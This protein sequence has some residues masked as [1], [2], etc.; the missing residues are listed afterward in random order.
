MKK[1]EEISNLNKELLKMV[2]FTFPLWNSGARFWLEHRGPSLARKIADAPGLKLWFQAPPIGD[3]DYALKICSLFADHVI[4]GHCGPLP[5]YHFGLAFPWRMDES[6]EIPPPT[7]QTAE[8]IG[9]PI[10]YH[11]RVDAVRRPLP[12]ISKQCLLGPVRTAVELGIVTYFPASIIYAPLPGSVWSSPVEILS[13]EG[14]LPKGHRFIGV[15]KEFAEKLSKESS[16]IKTDWSKCEQGYPEMD[17]PGIPKMWEWSDQAIKWEYIFS[18]FIASGGVEPAKES[19]VQISQMPEAIFKL[20]LPYLKEADWEDIYKIRE[21]EKGALES[22]RESILRACSN[23]SAVHG[24]KKFENAV[25]DIQERVVDKGIEEVRKAFKSL[26]FRKWA[27]IAGLGTATI[28]FEIAYF[29][30]L[31]PLTALV[32]G[33]AALKGAL[34]VALDIRKEEEEWKKRAKSEMPMYF[35]W[36]LKHRG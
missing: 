32:T 24:T 14:I 27:K 31:P 29:L 15:K 6:S 5:P 35:L 26:N 4:I 33:G 1:F 34:D 3:I 28:T 10:A 12:P 18:A 21:K 2:D 36:R 20:R 17:G 7:M 23:V 16:K 11:M 25:V 19:Y 30:G 9:K 13:R 22:F 8:E